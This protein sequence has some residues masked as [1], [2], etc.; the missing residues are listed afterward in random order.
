MDREAYSVLRGSFNEKA[1][2]SFIHGVTT[3]RQPTVKL[4]KMPDIATTEPWDGQD[5][6]PIEEELPLSEIMGWDEEL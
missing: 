6:A 5:A 4:S 1:I 2:T 3:G